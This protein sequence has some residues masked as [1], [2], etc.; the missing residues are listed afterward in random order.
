MSKARQLA[1]LGSVTTRLDEVG[2]TDGALSN[3]NLIINGAMQVAQRGTTGTSTGGGYLSVDRFWYGRSGYTPSMTRSQEADGPSGFS[4]SHKVLTATAATVP[5]SGYASIFQSIEATSLQHLNYGSSDAAP[6]TLSFWVKSNLTG[7]FAVSGIHFDTS[8]LRIADTYTIAVADTWEYK[9][10]TFVGQTTYPIDNDNGTGMRIEWCLSSGTDYTGGSSGVWSATAA[11]RFAGHSV[12]ITGTLNNYFQITGVQLEV[13]DTATPFEH[14]SY[15]DELQRC[16]RYYWQRS[17]ASTDDGIMN[18]NAYSTNACYG[19]ISFPTTMR[20]SP[21]F[22]FNEAGSSFRYYGNNS[23]QYISTGG[24]SISNASTASCEM[25]AV[26][27]TSASQG[28]GGWLRFQ[29]AS[30]WIAYDAEL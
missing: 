7:T 26:P 14:R 24:L 15:G 8:T 3:R 19:V 29:S 12:D 22:S 10:I 17:S 9:T 30:Q 20:S 13:G 4:N 18:M 23:A 21:T 11:D 28:S 5:V 2:N 1:D 25:L 16:Q 6:I 27:S